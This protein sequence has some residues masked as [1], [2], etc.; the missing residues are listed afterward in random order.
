MSLSDHIR[1]ATRLQ[2]CIFD[3]FSAEFAPAYGLIN[4]E[5]HQSC[6][7]ITPQCPDHAAQDVSEAGSSPSG[8]GCR[9]FPVA[10]IEIV[11]GWVSKKRT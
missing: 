2:V 8:S 1:T 4:Y 5:P 9:A 10:H 11:K 7:Y 6:K 3:W